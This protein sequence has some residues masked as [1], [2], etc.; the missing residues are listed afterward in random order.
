M[1]RTQKGQKARTAGKHKYTLSDALAVAIWSNLSVTQ[2]NELGV[3]CLA[4]AVNVR[5]PLRTSE[6]SLVK[7]PSWQTLLVSSEYMKS[8][9]VS[10][11]VS[12]RANC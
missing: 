11:W 9:R 10:A 12:Y 2:C 7:Q 4:Q 5:G 3:V 6:K 8:E 1:F